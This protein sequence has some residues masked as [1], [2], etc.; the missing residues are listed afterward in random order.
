[1]YSADSFHYTLKYNDLLNRMNITYTFL[2]NY[3]PQNV[4]ANWQRTIAGR[5][6][7]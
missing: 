4:K 6:K 2:V 1:M 5:V 3:V 7:V